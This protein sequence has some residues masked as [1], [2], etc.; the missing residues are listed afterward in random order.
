LSFE[1]IL[2]AP[3]EEVEEIYPYRR[4]WRTS[5][6]E[7]SILALA[8]AL[9]YV[10]DLLDVIPSA[11]NGAVFKT[12]FAALPLGLWLIVSYRGEQGALLPRPHLGGIMLLGGL[13]ASGVAIP[14]EEQVFTPE[15]WLPYTGFFGRVLGY[16]FTVGFTA[17]FLKYAALRYTLWPDR[18]A[19][20]LDGVAYAL[21]I[22]MGFATALNLRFALLADADLLATALRVASYTFSHLAVGVV[23]GFF[24]AELTIGRTPIFW[25]PMGLGIAALM[26]GL[27]YAFRVVAIVGGL[28]EAGSGA[29][30]VR[31]LVF[32]FGVVA[33]MFIVFAFV[34]DNADRRMESATRPPGMEL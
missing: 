28:S 20:R 21:A 6:I 5:W 18:I 16:M 23:M 15:R 22:S 2:L 24:L 34:I 4:V 1:P 10:L 9:I 25:L 7:I 26:S 13:V 27:Y 33:G 3:E 8:V 17:E 11:L 31:G 12:G 14:L 32:G 30:P 29:R 19:Q